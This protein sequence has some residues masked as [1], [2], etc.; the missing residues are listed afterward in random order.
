MSSYVSYSKLLCRKNVRLKKQFCKITFSPIK[1]AFVCQPD[2]EKSVLKDSTLPI[3]NRGVKRLKAVHGEEKYG[4]N[5]FYYLKST[6]PASLGFLS[7][8]LLFTMNFLAGRGEN[9]SLKI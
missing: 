1:I 4:K 3:G 8:G 5:G 6:L 2:F 7:E 9:R